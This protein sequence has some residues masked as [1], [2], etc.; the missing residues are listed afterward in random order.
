MSKQFFK[1]YEINEC[2]SAFQNLAQKQFKL[3][4]EAIRSLFNKQQQKNQ[5]CNLFSPFFPFF[6]IFLHLK[7][8]ASCYIHK[9][10]K[11]I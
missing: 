4:T 10:K 7:I 5:N 9:Q 2:D 6:S 3:Y 11:V 1:K 8:H